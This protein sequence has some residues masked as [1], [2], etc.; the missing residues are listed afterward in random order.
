MDINNKGQLVGGFGGNHD[1]SGRAF[2]YRNGTRQ[3]LGTL[4]DQHRFSIARAINNAEQVVGYSNPSYFTPSDKRAFI[5]DSV[6]HD[7]NNLIPAGSGWVLSEANDINDAGQIVGNGLLNGQERAFLLTPVK[8]LLLTEP[9]SVKTLALDSVTFMRGPFS[10]TTSHNF[11]SDHRTRIV[12]FARNVE[13]A[14]GEAASIVTV[15]AEDA[16][17]RIIFLPV[18]YVGKVPRFSWLTQVVVR[19]PDELSQGGDVQ[20]SIA[21]RGHTSNKA[22]ISIKPSA[23]STP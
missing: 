9:G 22:V 12:L 13:L 6:M 15:Q 7:L 5:Y 21:L 11:S 1:G 16:Q 8:P 4:S 14:S 2:L 10:M 3:D 20:V 18:E 17:H 19:L 23:T